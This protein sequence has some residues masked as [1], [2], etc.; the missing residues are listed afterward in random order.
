MKKIAFDELTGYIAEISDS[1]AFE[2]APMG[3]DFVVPYILNDSIEDYFVFKNCHMRGEFDPDRQEDTAVSVVEDRGH[4]GL[5][6]RQGDANVVSLWF[7]DVFRVQKSCPYHEIGHFWVKGFEHWRRIVYM[8]STLYD[9]YTYAGEAFCN[10]KEKALLPLTEFA[11][12]REFS[13]FRDTIHGYYPDTYEAVALFKGLAEEAGDTE[14]TKLLTRYEKRPSLRFAKRIARKMNAQK[15]APL[16]ELILTRLSKASAEHP[17]RDYGEK[18]NTEILCMRKEAEKRFL[19]AGYSG[20]YPLFIRGKRQ[21]LVTEEHPF[22]LSEMEY[23]DFDFRFQFM[24]S[25]CRRPPQYLCQGFFHGF[26]NKGYIE[27]DM[28][29]LL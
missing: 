3:A 14:F 13:Y 29:K 24:V 17:P 26:G 6:I 8:A 25:E 19:A 4:T 9:K 15:R 2:L 7:E 18:R 27:K 1:H 28:Q 10:A 23:K 5:I 21:V 20:T 16:Y 12:L 22:T 11:P